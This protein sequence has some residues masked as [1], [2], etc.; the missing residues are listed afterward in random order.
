MCVAIFWACKRLLA[1]LAENAEEFKGT[2]MPYYFNRMEKEDKD[3]D[4]SDPEGAVRT[5]PDDPLD[6]DIEPD[7]EL[8]LNK[9]CLKSHRVDVDGQNRVTP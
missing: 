9:W 7:K 3:E 2:I 1:E 4:D 8:P 6:S 5:G